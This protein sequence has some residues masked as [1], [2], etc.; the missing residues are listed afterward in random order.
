MVEVKKG[1]RG[2]RTSDALAIKINREIE[3]K[4]TV[5]VSTD[6]TAQRNTELNEAMELVGLYSKTLKRS[7]RPVNAIVKLVKTDNNTAFAISKIGIRLI[8][9]KEEKELLNKL[10]SIVRKK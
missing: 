1:W 8:G 9:T 3:D 4:I 6:S 5:A 7:K 2:L 10:E